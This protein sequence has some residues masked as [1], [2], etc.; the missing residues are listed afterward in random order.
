MNDILDFAKIN[1]G[2]NQINPHPCAVHKV[3]ES[4]YK[5]WEKMANEKAL[6]FLFTFDE[7]MPEFLTLDQLRISQIVHN[8]LSNAIK[9]T[10]IGAVKLG[11]NYT[12]ENATHG[13]IIV[14]I[15]DTGRGMNSEELNQFFNLL[16]RRTTLSPA[17]MAG[18]A[19]GWQFQKLN[20]TYEW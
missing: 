18:R 20:Q 16:N 12:P 3:F 14:R 5:S 19:L 9:F 13:K 8:I 17:I 2:K 4:F 10:D 6:D 7:N 1:E 11:V 15:E